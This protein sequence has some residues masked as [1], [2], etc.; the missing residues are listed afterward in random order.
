MMTS[1]RPPAPTNKGSQR[2][3][4]LSVG[5]FHPSEK[6]VLFDLKL[7][8]GKYMPMPIKVKHK[9]R[10]TGAGKFVIPRVCA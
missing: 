4:K 10:D 2:I 3:L 5:S 1:I 9:I 6:W 7:V 8:N